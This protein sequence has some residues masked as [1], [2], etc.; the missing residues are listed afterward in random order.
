LRSPAGTTQEARQCGL[1]RARRQVTGQSCQ[2]TKRF[3]IRLIQ[4]N[5]VLNGRRGPNL[6]A[7][8]DSSKLPTIALQGS[9]EIGGALADDR[10]DG[11]G[12]DGELKLVSFG[13]DNAHAVRQRARELAADEAGERRFAVPASVPA[14]DRRVGVQNLA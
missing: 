14:G 2:R 6:H 10:G 9:D 3:L 8:A 7:H 4:I 13:V 1:E 12:F 11:S 5:F